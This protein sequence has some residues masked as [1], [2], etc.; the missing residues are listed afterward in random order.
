MISPMKK[1]FTILLFCGVAYGAYRFCHKQTAGFALGK[2]QSEMK[3]EKRWELAPLSDDEKSF[4]KTILSQRFSYLGKGAQ[5]YVFASEDGSAVIKFFRISHLEIPFWF[6]KMPLPSGLEGWRREKIA[7]KE[8]KKEKDFTSYKLAFENLRDETGLLYVHLNKSDDLR[9][10][11]TLIDKIGIAH[12]L[13]LD[14]LQFIL[15]KRATPF[16]AAISEMIT[17]HE[18]EKMKGALAE[19]IRLFSKRRALGLFDKDPD[20][21]TNFGLIAGHPVQFD[22][23]RF[24]KEEMRKKDE[25]LHEELIRITDTFKKWLEKREPSLAEYLEEKINEA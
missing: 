25:P 10:K 17:H 20:L 23:G 15:Q 24:K 16:Y 2:I 7:L 8:S 12:E 6:Q 11:I 19:L 1:V 3:P 9:Q 14:N 18:I 13:D 21:K 4:V 5:C 22:I